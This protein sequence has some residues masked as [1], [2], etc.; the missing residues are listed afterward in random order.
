[1]TSREGRDLTGTLVADIV[2][3]LLSYVA[4]TEREFL[5][6]RQAEGIAAARAK[7]VRFGRTRLPVPAQ[8]HTLAQ[9]WFNGEISAVQAGKQLGLSRHTF[10]RRARELPEAERMTG[11]M[12]PKYSSKQE[13]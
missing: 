11:R 8:F 12:P 3:Q 9:Q 2:L 4:Q 1:M 5:R 7:G 13:F 6:I 10:M